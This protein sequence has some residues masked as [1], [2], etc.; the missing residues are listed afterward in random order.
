MPRA[1]VQASFPYRP[2]KET[3]VTPDGQEVQREKIQIVRK[4]KDLT[5]TLKAFEPSIIGLPYGT[6]PRLIMSYLT[7]Q[8]IRNRSPFVELGRN[9]TE[10]LAKL[11]LT[12]S[13]GPSGNYNRVMDQLTALRNT[14]FRFDWEKTQVVQDPNTG[15]LVREVYGGNRLFAAIEDCNFWFQ[16]TTPPDP[17]C[18]IPPDPLTRSQSYVDTSTN[19]SYSV[20]LNKTFFEEI[21][22]GAVPLRF[23]AL[24]YL[25]KSAL[26]MDL[27]CFFTYR[28]SYLKSDQLV[29]WEALKS[30]FGI[31]Y[32]R[33]ATFREQ[34]IE[35]LKNVKQVYPTLNIEV[36]PG[37]DQRGLLMHPS[38]TSV[39]KNYV[40]GIGKKKVKKLS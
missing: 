26:A 28:M 17:T 39:P 3:Y 31:G 2:L 34:F 5:V 11:G 10:F 16:V 33:V 38:P 9:K 14:L 32:S 12:G 4:N 25:S 27:Y 37:R 18:F 24:R 8:A 23:E 40:A 22:N 19:G 20:T 21:S 36:D 13:G 15:G 6:V 29:S 35:A 30:Q 1:L 7:E